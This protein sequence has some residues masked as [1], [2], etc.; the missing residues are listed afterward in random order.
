MNFK[1]NPRREAV[2]NGRDFP[3]ARLWKAILVAIQMYHPGDVSP[4]TCGA[5]Q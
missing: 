5:F 2:A 4:M 1:L 3:L